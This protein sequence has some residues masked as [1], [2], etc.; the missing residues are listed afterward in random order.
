MKKLLFAVAVAVTLLGVVRAADAS[1]AQ[2]KADAKWAERCKMS[3]EEWKG[4]GKAEQKAKRE[5]Y[6]AEQAENQAQAWSKRCNLTVEEWKKL[7][8][9]EQ[10][11]KKAIYTTE[12]AK[13][14]DQMWSKKL[15]MPIEEWKKLSKDEQLS[16]KDEWK[17][18]NK[19]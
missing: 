19:K 13:L 1:S 14:Q 8:K 12:Q 9:D 4:L 10:K 7:S 16:K 3:V 17:A 6:L 11:A 15:N 2:D 18:K 5:S